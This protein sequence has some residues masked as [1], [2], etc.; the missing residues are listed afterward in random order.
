MTKIE[1]RIF[2]DTYI[3]TRGNAEYK[4]HQDKVIN[5]GRKIME[6]LGSRRYL[7]LEYELVA[8]LSE[9][10]YMKNIY[11]AGFENGKKSR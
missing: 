8:G 4:A 6:C 10:I 5:L 7:F 11:R 1:E 2:I 9:G 3:D